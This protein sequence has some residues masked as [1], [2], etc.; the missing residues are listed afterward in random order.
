[1]D[2]GQRYAQ[3]AQQDHLPDWQDYFIARLKGSD[4]ALV[5]KRVNEN[6][7][8]QIGKAGTYEA[9]YA[10]L[11]INLTGEVHESL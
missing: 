1:M 6:R 3:D 4:T 7:S 8:D 10:W 5:F 11:K 2:Y 9:A